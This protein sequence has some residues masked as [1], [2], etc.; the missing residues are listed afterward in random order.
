MYPYTPR[1][2]HHGSIHHGPYTTVGQNIWVR[3][4]GLSKPQ[5]EF[6]NWKQLVSGNEKDK[7]LI[8]IIYSWKFNVQY[9]GNSWPVFKKNIHQFDM[10]LSTEFI[11]LKIAFYANTYF[12]YMHKL[13][14][15]G[16]IWMFFF[17]LLGLVDMKNFDL[18]VFPPS[19]IFKW[20][21]VAKMQC[22][23]TAMDLG[24]SADTNA[25]QLS[26]SKHRKHAYIR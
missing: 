3:L 16:E 4:S 11:S 1:P 26:Q 18:D 20:F 17:Q 21:S 19:H 22:L 14:K 9:F 8:C 2:I 13:C 15:I 12:S 5:N 24:A 25:K 6:M 7:S 23:C 10:P